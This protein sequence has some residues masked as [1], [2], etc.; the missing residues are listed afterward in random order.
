M[1]IIFNYKLNKYFY[2][3]RKKTLCCFLAVFLYYVRA[4]TK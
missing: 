4:P 3:D 2:D 1:G